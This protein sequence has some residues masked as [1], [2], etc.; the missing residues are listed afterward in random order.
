[1]RRIVTLCT[2]LLLTSVFA[3]SQN[4]KITGTVTGEN[5]QPLSDVSVLVKGT[6][7][8]TVTNSS[9]SYTI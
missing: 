9:G 8:G 2:I 1:M 5:G 4:R 6:Q 3:F 7:I